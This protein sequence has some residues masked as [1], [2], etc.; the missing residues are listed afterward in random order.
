MMFFSDA[1]NGWSVRQGWYDEK[2]V[3]KTTDGGSTWSQVAFTLEPEDQISNLFFVD[4]NTGWLCGLNGTVYHTGDG[5]TSWET[6]YNLGGGAGKAF[7]SIKFLDENTGYVCGANGRIRKTINGGTD[8]T[9][10][11]NGYTDHY[12][13]CFPVE[14]IGYAVGTGIFKYSGE[15]AV[16]DINLN[17]FEL[18]ATNYPNPFNPQTTFRINIPEKQN[19]MLK[20]FDIRG[21]L[22]EKMNFESKAAGIYQYQWNAG[23]YP[24]GTYYYML[25]T[26]NQCVFGKCLLIK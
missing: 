16:E 11:F 13:I 8:W 18:S 17:T 6:Q 15:T 25:K 5:G 12:D 14:N 20:I 26:S 9:D 10:D 3:W 19:A 23:N 7:A 2:S 22:I 21:K 24:S 1:N 4:A